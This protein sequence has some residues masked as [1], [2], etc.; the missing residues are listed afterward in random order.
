MEKRIR[1]YEKYNGSWAEVVFSYPEFK[2]AEEGLEYI[3]KLDPF[4]TQKYS[5][6]PEPVER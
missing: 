3:R 6:S 5:V 1:L 4:I 2:T